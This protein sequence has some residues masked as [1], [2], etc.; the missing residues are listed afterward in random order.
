MVN[1]REMARVIGLAGLAEIASSAGIAAAAGRGGNVL[2]A[3][4]KVP[5]FALLYECTVTISPAIDFGPTVEGHRRVI[6]IT[7]GTFRGPRMRGTVLNEGADWNLSRKDGAG[8]ADAAYYLRTDD[9]VL[10]RV[11]NQGVGAPRAAA[12]PAAAERFIM[13]THAAFE[14]PTGKYDWLNRGMFFGTLS[15]RRGV[16]DAVLIRMFHLV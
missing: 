5:A 16:R 8:S 15:I 3:G 6:P 14:A 2:P 9:Q 1:R 13:Y 11:V 10:I 7:G 12:D 4:A